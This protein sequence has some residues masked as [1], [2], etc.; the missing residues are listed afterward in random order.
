MGRAK[1]RFLGLLVCLAALTVRPVTAALPFGTFGSGSVS[2]ASTISVGSTSC[3]AWYGLEYSG[4]SGYADLVTSASASQ[5]RALVMCIPMPAAGTY[6]FTSSVYRTSHLTQTTYWHVLAVQNGVTLSLDHGGIPTTITAAGVK[7]LKLTSLTDSSANLTWRTASE[8]F[9][10]SAGD[11]TSYGYLVFAFVGSCGPGNVMRFD[12]I[13][14]DVPY[15]S[16]ATQGLNCIWVN[17]AVGL[18][19]LGSISWSTP[20]RT[21]FEP[22][23]NWMNTTKQFYPGGATQR[24]AMKLTGTI[25]IPETGTWNF[26]VG[27]DDGSK[28]I[29]NSTTVI[30][31]DGLHSYSTKTGS[32]S[33]SAGTYPIE[34]QF[35]ENTG[36]RGLKLEWQGPGVASYDTVPGSAFLT[37][38]TRRVVR[39]RELSP[40]E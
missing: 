18:S 4:A 2:S 5:T 19:S 26:R 8:T 36:N 30:N 32:I 34:V 14:T 3:G 21:S 40:V 16:T 13:N 27:S 25:T 24:F 28:V 23:I 38:S 39:W 37:S 31:H 17:S 20:V 9:T 11:V 15:A 6:S 1:I 12:N 22:Q 35:F 29:I 7:S 33:L 10:V